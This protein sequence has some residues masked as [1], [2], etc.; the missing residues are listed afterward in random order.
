MPHFCNPADAIME[1]ADRFMLLADEKMDYA[2]EIML[3]AD[4]KMDYADEK[5]LFFKNVSAPG[6]Y[7][8]VKMPL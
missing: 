7:P 4:R 8:T 5:M 2:D 6:L 3:L 1:N